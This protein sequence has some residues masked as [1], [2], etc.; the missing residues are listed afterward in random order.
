MPDNT[1]RRFASGEDLIDAVFDRKYRVVEL[2]A[3][4]DAVEIRVEET[5]PTEVNAIGEETFF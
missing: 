1:T 4:G 5:T 3:K 2:K